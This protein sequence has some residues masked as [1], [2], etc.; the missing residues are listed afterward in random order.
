VRGDVY[1]PLPP[2]LALVCED[3]VVG[4]IVGGGRGP[5]PSDR[6]VDVVEDEKDDWEVVTETDMF[7]EELNEGSGSSEDEGSVVGP[8]VET[9]C[10]DNEEVDED[11]LR[12]TRLVPAAA[13][14]VEYQHPTYTL[15][16]I[17][18]RHTQWLSISSATQDGSP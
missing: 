9:S 6:E 17:G 15:L 5:P 4:L 2:L 3:E 10:C 1:D 7:V 12:R 13:T 11:A 18:F 16:Y 14:S 8:D